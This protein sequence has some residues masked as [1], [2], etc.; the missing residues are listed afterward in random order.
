MGSNLFTF[1]LVDQAFQLRLFR[2]QVLSDLSAHSDLELQAVGDAT[3]M[4]QAA[5]ATEGADPCGVRSD[6]SHPLHDLF[7]GYDGTPAG[8]LAVKEGSEI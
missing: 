5:G 4:L 3:G 1:G 2:S 6:H 8:I 7:F